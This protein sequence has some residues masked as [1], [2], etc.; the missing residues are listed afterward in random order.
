MRFFFLLL[1]FGLFL[2]LLD[3][4]VEVF[5][6]GG[7]EGIV[8]VFF[9]GFVFVLLEFWIGLVGLLLLG[10]FLIVVVGKLFLV[11]KF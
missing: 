5:V 1:I 4:D 6:G 11:L 8:F 3:L 10:L 2:V 9:I 7:V